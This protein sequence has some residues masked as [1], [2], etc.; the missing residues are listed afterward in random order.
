[1][2]VC[3]VRQQPLHRIQ[4]G[5]FDSSESKIIFISFSLLHTIVIH[6]E[7]DFDSIST[8]KRE[9]YTCHFPVV[10]VLKVQIGTEQ[11]ICRHL[12]F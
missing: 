1:M 12:S 11:K 7:T 3:Y 5:C 9:Y 8:H 6:V 10:V 4:T 2:I